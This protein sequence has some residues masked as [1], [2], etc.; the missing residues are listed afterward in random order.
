MKKRLVIIG[1][2]A[3]G[4]TAAARARRISEEAE[5][6]L[7][8]RGPYVSYANCGLP[9]FLAGDIAQRSKLLLQTPKGFASRYRVR[10]LVQTEALE[11]DRVGR[12][13]RARGPDGEAWFPYDA[14]ILAQG[15]SPVVPSVPGADAPH[16]FE[17]WTVPDK[18][19]G[20]RDVLNLTGGHLSMVAEGG[21][22]MEPT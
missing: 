13:V 16:V 5:I 7:L 11:L 3:A 9:Y 15:G 1:G 2:V 12:R 19:R 4:A 6:T 22:E 17:L 8:E 10:A 18:E 20:F 21:F 14:L